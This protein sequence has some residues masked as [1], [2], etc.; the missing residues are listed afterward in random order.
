MRQAISRN[1][2]AV[3]TR[4]RVAGYPPPACCDG[5]RTCDL[6]DAINVGTSKQVS[7]TNADTIEDQLTVE[8]WLQIRKEEALRIDPE[9]AEV[10]WTWACDFDPY[11]VYPDLPEELQQVSRQYFARSPGSDFWVC[12][13]DLPVDIAVTLWKMGKSRK[14]AYPTGPGTFL[15]FDCSEREGVAGA[16]KIPFPTGLPTFLVV[17]CSDR[18][19]GVCFH[20]VWP[21]DDAGYGRTH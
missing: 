10:I 4:C 5:L 14:R 19:G 9:T 21:N 15:V 7:D 8:Q 17:D 2:H 1:R 18:E 12:F 20:V 13:N 3:S 11:G 16:E 6:E